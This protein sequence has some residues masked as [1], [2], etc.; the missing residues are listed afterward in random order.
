MM[1]YIAQ[2][3]LIALMIYSFFVQLGYAINGRPADRKGE[4]IDVVVVVVSLLIVIV[5]YYCVGIFDF[6]SG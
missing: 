5:L 2:V 3:I 6:N 1:I 4:Y